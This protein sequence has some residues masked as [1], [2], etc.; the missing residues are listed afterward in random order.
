MM[1]NAIICTSK[2]MQSSK[3]EYCLDMELN[4]NGQISSNSKKD[5]QNP[6]KL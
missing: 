3:R 2:I 1:E 5:L 6:A 4:D